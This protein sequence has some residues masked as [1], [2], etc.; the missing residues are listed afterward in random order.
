MAAC[1]ED[2]AEHKHSSVD[3]NNP[4]DPLRYQSGLNGPEAARH[5]ALQTLAARVSLQASVLAYEKVFLL[6]AAAFVVVLPLGFF[7]R[8]PRHGAAQKVAVD[9]E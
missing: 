3:R 9:V 6:Q 1:R 8:A 5:A 4:I 2:A 7:L